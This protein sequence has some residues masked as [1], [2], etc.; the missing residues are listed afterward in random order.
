MIETIKKLF[1]YSYLEP[2]LFLVQ[3]IKYILFF[4]FLSIFFIR[5]YCNFYITNIIFS[6]T[7]GIP[8]YEKIFNLDIVIDFSE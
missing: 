2:F 6:I 8:I 3:K 1:I 7:K 4:I 5:H